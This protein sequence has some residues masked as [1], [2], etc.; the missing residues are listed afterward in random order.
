MPIITVRNNENN[1]WKGKRKKTPKAER[2]KVVMQA[3][4]KVW[5]LNDFVP[6]FQTPHFVQ[7]IWKLS[8]SKLAIFINFHQFF[9]FFDISLLQKN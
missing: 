7:K 9:E 8:L 5:E 2:K 1:R 3:I 4:M 6:N